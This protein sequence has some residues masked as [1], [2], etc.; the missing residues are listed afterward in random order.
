MTERA[1]HAETELEWLQ[2][3]RDVLVEPSAD[4]SERLDQVSSILLA[5]IER[6]LRLLEGQVEG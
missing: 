6:E 4:V 2:K 3:C 5:M 1:N